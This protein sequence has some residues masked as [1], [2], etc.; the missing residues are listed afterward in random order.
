MIGFGLLVVVCSVDICALPLRLVGFLGFGCLGVALDCRVDLIEFLLGVFMVACF[1]F[2]WWLLL[3]YSLLSAGCCIMGCLF[4]YDFA[5]GIDSMLYFNVFLV[6][7]LCCFGFVR[8]L[9]L[10]WSDLLCS[11]VLGWVFEWYC[12]GFVDGWRRLVCL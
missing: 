4:C 3:K 2:V 11:Y 8:L 9:L 12:L 10:F 7:L 1:C 6:G 5:F